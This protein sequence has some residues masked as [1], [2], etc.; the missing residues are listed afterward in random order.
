LSRSLRLCWDAKHSI[1][2]DNLM[3]ALNYELE[4]ADV[5]ESS[6]A[7]LGIRSTEELDSIG[8]GNWAQSRDGA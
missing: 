7:D 3:S 6:P 5:A 1:V 4:A 8:A 2:V